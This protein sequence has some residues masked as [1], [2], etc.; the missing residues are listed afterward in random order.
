MMALPKTEAPGV[1]PMPIGTGM[2]DMKI[3][4]TIFMPEPA[5]GVIGPVML[6]SGFDTLL[7]PPPLPNGFIYHGAE[8]D[9]MGG[10]YGRVQG[11]AQA[12]TQ[13]DNVALFVAYSGLHD[14]G[15]LKNGGA[16]N[17][18]FHADLGWRADGNEFHL[19]AHGVNG[20]NKNGLLSPVELIAVDPRAQLAYPV[21]F[22]N[23]SIHLN[24]TG[25]YALGGGWSARSDLSLGRLV[26]FL[27]IPLGGAIVSNCPANSALLC[28]FGQPYLDAN[29]NQ[30]RSAG[31]PNYAYMEL[32]S[33]RTTS[34]GATTSVSN[35]ETLFGRPNNFT[36]GV[37]YNGANATSSYSQHLGVFNPGGGYGPDLG[38][39]NDQPIGVPQ[40]GQ[41]IANYLGS[42]ITDVVDVTD[43]LKVAASG[44]YNLTNI[45]QHDMQGTEPALNENRTFTHFSPSTGVSYALTPGFVAY[46]GYSET[47]RIFAPAGLF[48]EDR[49]AAC[50]PTFSTPPWFIADTIPKPAVY[51]TYEV[52]ARGQLQTLDLPIAPV[53]V[54]WNAALYRTDIADYTYLAASTG[55]PTFA[56]VGN[57]RRQ[58]AKLGAEFIA[59]PWTTSLSYVYT[60]ATFRDAFALFQP[61]NPFAD[62]TGHIYVKPGDV[63]PNEPRHVLRVS[64]KYN[65]TKD[66][67]VG[68]SLRAVS[69]SYYLGDEINRL[70]KYPGYFVASLNTQYHFDEHLEV[71]GIVE[72]AFCRQYAIAGG[73]TAT[74]EIPISEAPGAT[75]PRAQGLGQPFSVYGG[76]K[77]RF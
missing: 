28:S 26:S 71:F 46:G 67:A 4:N 65:V 12:G 52:G 31:V 72:N 3:A 41:A 58:G 2:P 17:Q 33:S 25:S 23:E 56:S 8:I 37:T 62:F 57:V 20:V 63:L 73:L 48:C 30:F 24:F 76:V 49:D 40:E 13:V 19:V 32:L 16:E 44:R 53:Q 10:S 5:L 54:A 21:R 59:G 74:A 22:G 18:Q 36:A 6:L 1:F 68:A 43:K 35:V 66:W 38:E 29:G 39:T 70:G 64:T 27:G 50:A 15:W 14:D 47:Q 51:R 7:G 69:S 9:I 45:D 11:Y 61:I 42:Y 60:D 77:Y 55:R 75:N 34:W